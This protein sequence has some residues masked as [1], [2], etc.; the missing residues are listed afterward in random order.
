MKKYFG[1]DGIRGRFGESTMCPAFAY[2]LARALTKYLRRNGE[3]KWLSVIIGR[4]TRASG[5]FLTEA[6]VAG[7][8]SH[9]IPVYDGGIVPTPAV[10]RSVI[11]QKAALGIAVTASHNPA[12]DNGIKLF[13]SK[14]FKYDDTEEAWIESL[15]DEEPLAPKELPPAK[16][17]S[18]DVYESY[19]SAIGSLMEPDSLK[20]WKIVL[21]T[22]NGATF[23]TSPS[24]FRSWGAGLYLIGDKPD[25]WNI[26][27]GVGS[28]YPD[29]LARTVI[30]QNADIGIAHD[31]DG[32]RLVV[33]DETG[34]I[35][36]GDRLLGLLGIYGMQVGS[37]RAGKLVTTIHSNIGLDRAISDAGGRVERVDVGDRNV[38]KRMR[39]IGA[40]FGGESSGHIIFSDLATTGDGL[41]AAV[42]LIELLL[43]TKKNLSEL[44]KEVILFPQ[45]TGN[46]KVAQ[47]LP[48]AQL[49]HLNYTKREIENELGD[50]GRVLIRYSGTEPKIRL[51]VEGRVPELVD[52]SMIC[53]EDAVRADLSV[54]DS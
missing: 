53:L 27:A 23:R 52:K 33:C 8:N 47:K 7:F 45:K 34:Q 40:N 37:L 16:S 50:E 29:Q 14:G 51:L 15:I 26:N 21:D 28:E 46:L 18:L 24:V 36:D 35:V 25:G 1:T 48:I 11:K 19:Q 3:E 20:G 2:R 32:D 13:D 49:D 54:I 39:E 12:H 44:Q 30:E 6:L 9:S 38:A 5:K 43:N 22:A 10:A 17:D 31:G 4:D 41:L 42:K